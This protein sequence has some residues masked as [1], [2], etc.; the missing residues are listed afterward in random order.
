[1]YKNMDVYQVNCT[2]Y[3][4]LGEN[5]DAYV[6]ARAI[7]MF[8]PGIPQVYYVGILAGKNDLTLLEKTKHGR[9][10][11]RHGYTVAEIGEEV[12]RTVVQKLLKLLEFRNTFPAFDGVC[13]TVTS[14][15]VLTMRR[16]NGGYTAELTADMQKLSFKI[17]Y[18]GPDGKKN[19]LKV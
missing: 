6:V 11:N 4:A 3:S 1:M 5:D 18:S 16:V 12:K 17:T 15:A 8:A 7:Q 14:G 10:I 2:Y 19:T 9:D 13:E